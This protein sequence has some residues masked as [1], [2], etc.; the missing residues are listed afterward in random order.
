MSKVIVASKNPVKINC[1]KNAFSTAFGKDGLSFDGISVPSG[2]PDQPMTSQETL[3]GAI[4]RAKN[5][6][7]MTPDAGY[8][9]GI[10][11]GIDQND[12]NMEAFAWVVILS[13]KK[14]G[15]AKTAVFYLPEKIATLVNEGVELGHADDLV[16]KRD[17]SKQKDGAIGILTNGIIDRE[18]YYEQAVIMALIPF[19]NEALY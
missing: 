17:N 13:R 16:F 6:K 11:G 12:G 19:M 10:E 3:E 1:V 4:N 5:A 7:K 2:V 8:W 15:K 14:L 18:K 9:V